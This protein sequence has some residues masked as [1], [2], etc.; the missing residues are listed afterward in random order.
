MKEKNILYSTD[1]KGH[2]IRREWKNQC[3][4]KVFMSG[5]CQG[6]EGHEGDHWNYGPDGSYYWE[7]QDRDDIDDNDS[8][9]GS[10]PPEHKTYTSP[11]KMAKHYYMAHYEDTEVIDPKVIA[12]LEAG[13]TPEK[14]ATITRPVSAAMAKKLEKFLPKKKKKK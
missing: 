7:I 3:P 4:H 1:G 13:K 2:W 12:R 5:R 6:V 8:V 10:C 11:K 14:G 9:A